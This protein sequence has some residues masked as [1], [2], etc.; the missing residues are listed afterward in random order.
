MKRANLVGGLL[1]A[2]IIAVPALAVAPA[3]QDE[4][5]MTMCA[6]NLKSMWSSCLNYAAMYGR[7]NGIMQTET[8]SDFWLKL[9]RTPKPLIERVDPF[10]CPLAAHDKAL[11][12]TSYRGPARDVNRMEDESPVGADFDGN[13]GA[14]K[15]GNVIRKL[16]DVRDYQADDPVWKSCEEALAGTPPLTKAQSLEKRVADLEKAVKE[17]TDLV[18][19]IKAR[20]EKKAK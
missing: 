15:G 6:S 7:P 16:G 5:R 2:A 12:Q 20:L 4:R 17:L 18:N 13:H 11:D 14:G 8:G 1:A 10:F 9:K 3:L 19:E